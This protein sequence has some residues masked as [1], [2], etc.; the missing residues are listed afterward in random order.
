MSKI[1]AT[2]TSCTIDPDRRRLLGAAA[3][4]AGVLLINSACSANTALTPQQ[5]RGPFYPL[6]IPLDHDNDLVTVAGNPTLA[7]GEIVNVVGRVLDINGQPVT[8]ARIEIW[9][10]DHNGR[11]HHP[12]DKRDS[13]PRD[14]N[15][16]G[17]GRFVTGADGAYRFR[18][19]KPVPYPGRTPHIHF[20]V[21]GSGVDELVTQMY[22]A[23]APGN[24]GDFLFNKIPDALKSRV[25]VDFVAVSGAAEPVGQF[26]IV[27]ATA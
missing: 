22:L 16:Q 17:Y 15:F 11:Y 2:V 23:G 27:V 1:N 9:Q 10:C 14:A 21:S 20:A 3:A 25:L 26:D 13:V 24:A 12:G 19:I 8:G 7:G 5:T 4:A 6:E 18:T